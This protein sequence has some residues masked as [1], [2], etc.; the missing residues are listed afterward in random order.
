M[1]QKVTEIRNEQ[2]RRT[3]YECINRDPAISKRQWCE[4]NGVKFRSLMYWQRKF[5]L[6]A[7]AQM[8]NNTAALPVS[9]AA[10][11]CV[12]VFADVTEKL[13]EIHADQETRKYPGGLSPMTHELMIQAGAYQIYVNGSIQ[14][15]TLEKVM[16]VMSRA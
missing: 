6:E 5:R 2:W 13:E 4:D 14:M 16:K 8:E 10:G 1:D 12:P 7:L 3:V 11:T 9:T 15:T